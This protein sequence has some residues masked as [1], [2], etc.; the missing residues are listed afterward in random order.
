LA[1]LEL[2]VALEELLSQT[3]EFR[4]AGSEIHEHWHRHGVRSMPSLIIRAA[5]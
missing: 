3:R 4:L 1:R 2:R 5:S